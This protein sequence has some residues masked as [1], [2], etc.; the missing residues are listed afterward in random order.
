MCRFPCA[1]NDTM[2]RKCYSNL[3]LS[4][5][6]IHTRTHSLSLS[7]SHT[8]THTHADTHCDIHT[9]THARTR[10]HTRTH[11][12]TN[13][14]QPAGNQTQHLWG[15]TTACMHSSHPLPQTTGPGRPQ[16]FWHRFLCQPAPRPRFQTPQV[17]TTD[18]A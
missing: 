18:K 14:K 2:Y 15:Y 16:W 8:H 6:H 5:H 12:R 3:F 17:M 13:Y 10:T 11:A 1:L 9:H 4:G 7:L